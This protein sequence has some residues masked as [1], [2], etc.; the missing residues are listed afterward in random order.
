[1]QVVLSKNGLLSKHACPFRFVDGGFERVGP[2]GA[3]LPTR[4]DPTARAHAS[5]GIDTPHCT[6][7]MMPM[8]LLWVIRLIQ[9]EGDFQAHVLPTTWSGVDRSSL[10]CA[11]RHTSC[12]AHIWRTKLHLFTQC[13]GL[14]LSRAWY[15]GVALETKATSVH[16]SAVLRNQI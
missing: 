12:D 2:S 16:V 13:N 15:S 10:S 9:Y 7:I 1:M 3:D 4:R 8:H 6:L 11:F 14:L 5:E